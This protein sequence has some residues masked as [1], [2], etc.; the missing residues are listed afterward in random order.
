MLIVIV[1]TCETSKGL[2]DVAVRA[3]DGRPI[4]T[5]DSEPMEFSDYEAGNLLALGKARLPLPA[6]PVIEPPTATSADAAASV[7]AEPPASVVE[8]AAVSPSESTAPQE[9]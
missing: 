2:I 6:P 8:A 7:A 9:S 1:A 5:R 3:P 4:G